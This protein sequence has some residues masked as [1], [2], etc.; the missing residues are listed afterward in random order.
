VRQYGPSPRLSRGTWR[1]VEVRPKADL[2]H[3]RTLCLVLGDG[4]K[5]TILLDQGFGGWRSQ[6]APRHDFRAKAAAQAQSIRSASYSVA[7]DAR[8]VP[9]LLWEGSAATPDEN[10][11]E[12][13]GFSS[14]GSRGD[15]R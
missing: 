10:S 11:S 12:N 13:A 3:A 15:R 1:H 8:G 2:P 14:R 6:G 5:I 4:R 7:A 9:L